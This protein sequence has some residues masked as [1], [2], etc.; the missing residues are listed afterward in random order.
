MEAAEVRPGRFIDGRSPPD[1]VTLRPVAITLL[2]VSIALAGC[3]Q[4]PPGEVALIVTQGEPHGELYVA[5]IRLWN[6]ES[7]TVTLA[8]ENFTLAVTKGRPAQG[9][10][11]QIVEGDVD[12]KVI[13][14][15]AAPVQLPAG[16]VFTGNLTFSW[17]PSYDL[18]DVVRWARSEERVVEAGIP[19][20]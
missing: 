16:S 18:P 14:P 20:G 11:I 10:A 12:G 3:G 8:M 6:N 17:D 1:P 19:V 2:L 15:G 5:G 13:K 7:A 4:A 9:G